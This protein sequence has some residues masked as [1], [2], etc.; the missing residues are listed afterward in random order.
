MHEEKG[1]RFELSAGVREFIGE[2]GKVH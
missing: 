2:D 1:V